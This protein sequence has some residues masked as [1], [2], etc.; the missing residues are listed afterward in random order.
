MPRRALLI[1]GLS[2]S[3][4]GWWRVDGWLTAAGW[5]AETVALRGHGGSGPAD[6]YALEAY[7]ADV[8]AA[9]APGE[10]PWDLV[11]AHSLGGA[12]ATVVAAADPA[13]A[14]R[15]VL[16]DP[17]WHVSPEQW[18]E[19]MADQLSE[20]SYT[21]ETLQA[22]KPHWHARDVE[23]KLAGI[24]EVE[25]DAVSRTFTDSVS[26]DVRPAAARLAVPTLVLAGDP[27][28]FTM[29]DPADARAA[30][31]AAPGRI[32]VEVVPG[33]GHSPH[34]DEPEATRELLM[35]FADR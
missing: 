29:L 20:L 15:L 9:R 27:H 1:H 23:A 32:D 5:Q 33:A 13:W 31:D 21:R 2:S 30:A 35:H 12:I 14:A 17:V 22:A 26:W 19:T 34:R 8:T 7:A 10:R 18:D 16:L 4:A 6:S 24:A 3:P 28:V 11:V 25:R